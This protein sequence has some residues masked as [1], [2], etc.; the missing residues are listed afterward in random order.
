MM[1]KGNLH[2]EPGP[3][4][5]YSNSGSTSYDVDLHQSLPD[6]LRGGARLRPTDDVEL[7]LFGD[8][9]RW[10][11]MKSQ[12]IN[13]AGT[14]AGTQCLVY[15]DGSTA[16]GSAAV[17]ANVPRSWR[18]TFGVRAG[19]SYWMQPKVEVFAGLGYES[20]AVPDSTLEPGVIDGDNF[21][22]AAGVRIRLTELLYLAVSYTHLQYL[23]RDNVGKSTLA[24]SSTPEPPSNTTAVQVPTFAQD[25][26]GRYTQWVG[27]AD[28]NLEVNF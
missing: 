25:G 20:G 21:S 16:T 1:L 23:D 27:I 14:P 28:A 6:V 24:A 11:V 10:S 19:A 2:Y 15:P 3:S 5:Y 7:R 8:L 26:G 13:Q 17:L 22:L 12:C 18:D 9:T 4:P